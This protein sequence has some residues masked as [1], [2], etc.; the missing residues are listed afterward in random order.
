[1]DIKRPRIRGRQVHRQNALQLNSGLS[2]EQITEA[3]FRI[4]VTIPLLDD[5]LGSLRTGFEEGQVTDER[6]Y[7]ASIFHCI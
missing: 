5:V 6:N 4:N 1:M 2:E 3:Y 7:A